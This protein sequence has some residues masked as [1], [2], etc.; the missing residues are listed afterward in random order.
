MK[1]C[2]VLLFLIAVLM[3]VLSHFRIAVVGFTGKKIGTRTF[4]HKG[5]IGYDFHFMKMHINDGFMMEIGGYDSA[6]TDRFANPSV[7]ASITGYFHSHY[8][9]AYDGIVMQVVIPIWSMIVLVSIPIWFMRYRQR[10][11]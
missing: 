7:W 4:V 10:G 3:I 5:S 1:R 6:E 9:K 2:L 8:T 11:I